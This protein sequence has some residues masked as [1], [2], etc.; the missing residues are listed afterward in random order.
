MFD[1]NDLRFLIAVADSGSTLA[2]SRAM[3][4]S[5]TTVARRLKALEEALGL[6]LFDRRQSGYVPTPEGKKLLVLARQVENAAGRVAERASASAREISGIVR[7]TTPEI[8]ATT[9]LPPILRDLHEV[10]PAIRIELDTSHEVRDLAAGAADIAL[11]SN[12]ADTSSGLVGR[13]VGSDDW[14]LYCSRAY[15]DANGVPRTR[16]ELS[17]HVVIGGGGQEVWRQYKAWLDRNN[18]AGSVAMRHDTVTGLLAAVRAGFGVAVLP[19]FFAD[20]D[21]DLVRCL[22]PMVEDERSLWLLTHERLRHVPRIRIV[23]DFLTERLIR[24]AR[25]DLDQARKRA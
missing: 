25:T 24:P 9:V 11:R 21:P 6:I 8:Y 7:L 15:A 13:R 5:Q 19:G 16:A 2:A 10:Q 18:L 22:P 1:W 17:S 12:P 3:R 4:V 14:T 23:M 20:H